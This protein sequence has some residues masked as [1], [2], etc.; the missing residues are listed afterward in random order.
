MSNAGRRAGNAVGGRLMTNGKPARVLTAT[1]YA[2]GILFA[3][4]TVAAER[5]PVLEVE[6]AQCIQE[7]MLRGFVGEALTGYVNACAELKR[8]PPPPDLKQFSADP[9]AC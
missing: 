3:S 7:G 5:N 6:Q 4:L 1:V 8:N 9:A 2:G